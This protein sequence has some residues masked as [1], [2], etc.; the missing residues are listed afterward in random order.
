MEHENAWRKEENRVLTGLK[1]MDMSGNKKNVGLESV[2]SG[3]RGNFGNANANNCSVC[4]LCPSKGQ[5][6]SPK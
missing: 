5:S 1:W 4:M 2:L 3:L 6:S